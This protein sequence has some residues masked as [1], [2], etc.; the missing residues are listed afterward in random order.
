[1]AR[2]IW[3][4]QALDDLEA[5]GDYFA[6][7][8]PAYAQAFVDGAFGSVAMLGAFPNM[9]RAVPELDDAALRE[10]IY[11]GY[12]V[13]HVVSSDGEDTEVEVLSVVHAT[14]QFGGGP[15]LEPG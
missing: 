11:R 9:G 12:R 15:G 3:S 13:F 8:A 7:E 4:P 10:V 6:R 14:R 1:M 2:V 5:I